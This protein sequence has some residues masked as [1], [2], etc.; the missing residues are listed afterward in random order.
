MSAA[1]QLRLLRL[2]AGEIR[3]EDLFRL[4][5]G[6]ASSHGWTRHRTDTDRHVRTRTDTCHQ[7]TDTYPVYHFR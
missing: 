5:K 2:N 3:D 4:E 1:T 7:L 6:E